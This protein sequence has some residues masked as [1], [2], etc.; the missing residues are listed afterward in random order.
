MRNLILV[1]ILFFSAGALPIAQADSDT[2]KPAV[3]EKDHKK[4]EASTKNESPVTK[5]DDVQ[6]S[7]GTVHCDLCTTY[8]TKTVCDPKCHNDTYA[9]GTHS[10]NCR[11][12]S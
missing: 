4:T 8:C 7:G 1:L 2:A 11:P 9:C 5:K 10:C 12:G 6:S 3:N